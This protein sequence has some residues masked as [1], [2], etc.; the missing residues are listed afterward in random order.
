MKDRLNYLRVTLAPSASSLAL[1]SSASSL[2]A[3]SLSI[4]GAPSTTSLASFKPKP[5]TSRTTL[6]TLTLLAPTSVNSTLNSV[7][8]SSA[9]AAGPAT[10]TPAAADTP[11]SS[12]HAFT[13]SFNSNTVKLLIASKFLSCHY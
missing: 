7:F 3:P 4:L 8:S 10:T 13:K 6:I 1:I 2:V 12:S 5:V 11:N 9:T